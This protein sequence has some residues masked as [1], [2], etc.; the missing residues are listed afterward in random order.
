MRT[1]A[2]WAERS[3][4]ASAD[5]LRSTHELRAHHLSSALA[6]AG[7][8]RGGDRALAPQPPRAR[9]GPALGRAARR[10]AAHR[11]WI[12]IAPALQPR[13]SGMGGLASRGDADHGGRDRRPPRRARAAAA[14][15][16]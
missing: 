15:L 5:A 4:V 11:D 1:P 13:A 3:T 12:R 16:L 8:D 14:P 7:I 10:R 9:E 2:L 6:L